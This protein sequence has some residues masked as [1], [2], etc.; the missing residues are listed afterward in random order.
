MPEKIIKW[1]T[2]EGALFDTE[3]EA[4]KHENFLLKKEL[5][6]KNSSSYTW[7]PPDTASSSYGSSGGGG[8]D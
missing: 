1:R 6:R 8:H 7:V 5:E 4:L 3:L 2:E